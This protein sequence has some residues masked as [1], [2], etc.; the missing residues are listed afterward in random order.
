M[1]KMMKKLIAMAAALVMIVTLLPAVGVRAEGVTSSRPSVG[2]ITI[3]KTSQNASIPLKGAQFSIYQLVKFQID[4]NNNYVIESKQNGIDDSIAKVGDS[5][6]KIDI[7]AF[8]TD[9]ANANKDNTTF[10]PY[11]VDGETVFTTDAQGEIELQNL[12][13]GIYMVREINAPTGENGVTYQ[14]SIPFFISIPMTD[15]N[16]NNLVYDVTATPKNTASG[17]SKVVDVPTLGTDKTASIGDPVSYTITVVAPAK[18]ST[19]KVVDKI[20][21]LD[22]D[23]DS[24]QVVIKGINGGKDTTLTEEQLRGKISFTDKNTTDEIQNDERVMTID[25]SDFMETDVYVGKTVVITYDAIVAADAAIGTGSNTNEADVFYGND[26]QDITGTPKIYTYGVQLTKLGESDAKLKDVEFELYD[27]TGTQIT[28]TEKGANAEGKFVT[29]KDGILKIKGLAAGKYALKEVKTNNDYTLLTNPI[30]FEIKVESDI[31]NP[32]FTITNN[33]TGVSEVEETVNDDAGNIY[34][35]IEVVNQKG[36]TL[37]STGG[38]GTYLFTIGGIVI[39]AGAA[40]A[41]IAM[42]KRA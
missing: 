41:L 2:S 15:K 8:D 18:N 35:A 10:T 3:E 7:S 20:T 1:K 27:A 4:G 37:P 36:F 14:K 17:G 25:L 39:M 6:D 22:Y 33:G 13:V 40:F 31:N 29:D 19:F 26:P 28:D 23:K 12:P 34:F 32:T 9:M 30:E 11:S 16:G 24:V 38:M 5:I 42:K 21:G